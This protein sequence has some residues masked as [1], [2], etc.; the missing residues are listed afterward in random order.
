[1]GIPVAATA[2]D[3]IP[4][5]VTHEQTG[6]LSQPQDPSSLAANILRLIDQPDEAQRMAR[7]AKVRVVP[8]FGADRMLEQI[9]ELYRMLLQEKGLLRPR[10]VGASPLLVPIGC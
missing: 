9:D 4:E 10:K 8:A 3:G 2:V 1:M 5:L 7:R 6:L